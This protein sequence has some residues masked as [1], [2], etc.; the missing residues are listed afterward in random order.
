[1]ITLTRHFKGHMKISA[2]TLHHKGHYHSKASLGVLDKWFF[3]FSK[4]PGH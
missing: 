4:A 2:S 1:M 3:E